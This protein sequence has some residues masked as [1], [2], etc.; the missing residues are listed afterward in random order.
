[1][2]EKKDREI[3]LVIEHLLSK[4]EALSST[5]AL[6]KIKQNKKAPGK[7]ELSFFEDEEDW[8]GN[9]LE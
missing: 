1:L 6:P 9:W 8:K 4:L 5:P 7:M 3:D 2:L